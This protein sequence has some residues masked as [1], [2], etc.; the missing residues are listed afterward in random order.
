MPSV[1]S[2]TGNSTSNVGN[3]SATAS[4]SGTVVK[5]F[6][7]NAAASQTSADRVRTAQYRDGF[8]SAPHGRTFV[9]RQ[10]GSVERSGTVAGATVRASARG[11]EFTVSGQAKPTLSGAGADIALDLSV[12][13][14][15]GSAEASASKDFNFKLRGED[16]TV[17][18]ELAARGA[19]GINGELHLK[20]HAG[21]DGIYVDGEASGF[22]GAR[23]ELA[24]TI[25]VSINGRQ[26]AD[27]ALAASAMV[28]VAGQAQFHLGRDGFHASAGAAAGV[29]FGVDVRGNWNAEALLAEAP[30]FIL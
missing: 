5:Q 20:V 23:G 24:G 1:T 22:A 15:L 21:K 2:R 19:V 25:S 3:G 14:R 27:A 11:P 6:G 29:G 16:V 7:S 30:G 13:A 10:T 4:R 18:V 26:V 9:S 17:H 12:N 8:D 28:G